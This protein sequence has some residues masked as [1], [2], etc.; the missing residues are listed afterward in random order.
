M[1][2]N[3]L[4]IDSGLDWVAT[5]EITIAASGF[6]GESERRSISSYTSA[7]GI[8][9]LTQNIDND[10]LPG[11]AIHNIGGYNVHIHGNTHHNWGGQI[12]AEDRETAENI[13]VA[14][15]H[16]KNLYFSNMG[17]NHNEAMAFMFYF[18]NTQQFDR[19]AI[20][21]K[22]VFIEIYGGALDCIDANGVQFK[23]NL[24]YRPYMLGLFTERANNIIVTG[25]T[26]MSVEDEEWK[27]YWLLKG[28]T[29]QGGFFICPFSQH[30]QCVN[31]TFSNNKVLGSETNGI[32]T[33]GLPCANASSYAET[34]HV[35]YNNTVSSSTW[36]AWFLEANH[37]ETF[38][39]MLLKDFT[40]VHNLNYSLFIENRTYSLTL[41][42][43]VFDT[44]FEAIGF[45]DGIINHTY[46]G[47]FKNVQFIGLHE[48]GTILNT[49]KRPEFDNLA[50]EYYYGDPAN[51]FNLCDNTAIFYDAI[52]K[53]FRKLELSQKNAALW[54]SERWNTYSH[55]FLYPWIL[56]ERL[57]IENTEAAY[58]LRWE[59]WFQHLIA[60]RD[61]V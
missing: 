58:F 39:C 27:L 19:L 49:K 33:Q 32:A 40:M 11:T 44:C 4:E 15:I 12:R 22:S 20:I 48:N 36:T 25:N 21:E 54:V 59:S 17:H 8:L 51:H 28:L 9:V 61:N 47:T 10:H 13:Y 56:F 46:N 37:R 30:K 35:Y 26:I 1:N 43:A 24:I 18:Y 55:E 31:V 53:N 41:E 7:T 29:L 52:I 2:T 38:H 34:T 57:R 16:I 23:D 5:D 6:G 60:F 50:V 45:G 14:N 42:N 3:T